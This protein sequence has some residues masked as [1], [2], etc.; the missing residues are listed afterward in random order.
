MLAKQPDYKDNESMRKLENL[1]T[2]GKFEAARELLLHQKDMF[3]EGLFHYNL[4]TLY[5]R[6]GNFALGRYHLEKALSKNFA[7]KMLFNNLGT[8]KAELNVLD[9]GRSEDLS[10]RM[11][12]ASLSL[13]PGIWLTLTLSLFL[14]FMIAVRKKIIRGFIL[15]GTCLLVAMI[16]FLYGQLCL[17][18]MHHVVVLQDAKVYEGPSLIYANVGIVKGGSKIIVSKSNN[19]QYFIAYPRTLSGW[20]ERD[21]LGFL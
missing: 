8:V 5:A 16:P 17:K 11:F 19:D 18:K 15:R 3:S 21:Y 6:E 20:I 13:P 14:G 1:Y 4:G 7:N 2:Q 9:L 12:D 10:G